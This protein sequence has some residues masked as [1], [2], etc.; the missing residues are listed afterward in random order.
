MEKLV[1]EIKDVSEMLGVSVSTLY[2]W[3]SEKK[4]PC[5]KVGSLVKFRQSEIEKWLDGN[6]IGKECLN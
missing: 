6:K 5:H 2:K 1:L 3:V 4:I